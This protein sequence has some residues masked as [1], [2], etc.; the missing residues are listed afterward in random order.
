MGILQMPIVWVCLIIFFALLESLTMALTPIWFAAG[1]LGALVASLYGFNLYVQIGT[2]IIISLI[3][4][5]YTRPVAREFLQIG[6]IKTNSEG[7]IGDQAL[8]IQG[9]E[10]FKTGQVKIRGQVWTAREIENKDVEVGSTV[11]VMAIE[12]VKLIVRRINS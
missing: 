4:L 5:A 2:F 9:I 12:G 7:L 1:A 11:E 6:K 3:M 10:Q 8:V